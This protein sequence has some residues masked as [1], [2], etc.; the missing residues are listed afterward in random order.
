VPLTIFCCALAVRMVYLT[1]ESHSPFFVHR[2]TD[3]MSYHNRALGW[4]EGTWPRAET[5]FWPPLYPLFLGV[6]YQAI[7][8]GIWGLKIANAIIGAA[9][10]VLTWAIGR[11]VFRGRFVPIAAAVTCSLCGT[12]VFFDGELL[13]GTL[14]VFLQLSSILLLLRAARRNLLVLWA[15]AGLC[16]GISAVNRGGTLLFLPVALLWMYLILKRGWRAPRQQVENKAPTPR[17]FWKPATALIIA[18]CAVV[19]PVGWHNV[20]YD[21]PQNLELSETPPRPLAES[22]GDF[23]TGG[24]AFISSNA[25]LNFY[26]GNH[27]ALR[28][29]IHVNHPDCFA[30]YWKAKKEPERK[31]IKAPGEQ[32][33]YLFRTTLRH[34][35]QNP[36][37]WARVMGLK[38]FQLVSG[39]EIPRNINLYAWRNYSVL[40]SALLWKH[41]VAVPMGIIIPL[42]IVGA[43]LAWRE[44]DRHLLLLGCLVMQAVFVL[45]FFVT[46]RYRLPMIPLLSL[47]GAYALRCL[48][49]RARRRQYARLC[50]PVGLCVGL[51]IVSNY[52]VGAM[53]TKHGAYE[54]D[55]LAVGLFRNG[56]PD[57]AM[58]YLAKALEIE[59][60]YAPAHL[61]LGTALLNEN[62]LEES[63]AE[64]SQAVDVFSA[65]GGDS[66]MLADAH[67]EFGKALAKAGRLEE[68]VLHLNEAIRLSPDG[69]LAGAW[70][71]ETLAS[72]GRWEEAIGIARKAVIRSPG[73][74]RPLDR[75][76]QLLIDCP[77]EA[78]AGDRSE[79]VRL[80]EEACELTY[81]KV[82]S[83]L[84]TLAKAYRRAGQP[85]RAAAVAAEAIRLRQ[86]NEE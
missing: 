47:Y 42:G 78:L 31:G 52:K 13:S 3:V 5:F 4:L 17:G 80:A 37:D 73:R 32:S 54:Y 43:F 45:A 38:L 72:F 14:D 69:Q 10:C 70:L 27:W 82:P 51:F 71:L 30:N 6:L 34:I 9:S 24:F 7:G 64:L 49:D 21:R 50:L 22:L 2:G 83:L 76:A 75:L 33:R 62:R 48:A 56:H 1:E 57:E 85:Q 11:R 25:G 60:T 39:S 35:V 68:S 29:V 16:L 79:A 36:V 19:F 84:R 63:I 81:R 41:G 67:A 65:N 86:V 44:S 74:P 18:L 8:P 12:F 15:V 20:R 40:L 66:P 61:H 55:W 23:L 28:E 59:P 77:D 26:L 53:N 46:A 58:A